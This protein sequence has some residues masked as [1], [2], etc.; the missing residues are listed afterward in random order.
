MMV[1]IGQLV[2]VRRMRRKNESRDRRR[3]TESYIVHR[4]RL[5]SC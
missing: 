4:F 2:E 5:H 3:A 1:A